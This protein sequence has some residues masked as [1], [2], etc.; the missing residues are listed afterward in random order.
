MPARPEAKY[1]ILTENNPEGNCDV[2]FAELYAMK[3][4]SYACWQL[5]IG[6]NGTEHFQIFLAFEKKTRL[7]VIQKILPGCHAEIARNPAEA[8]EY[9]RKED[10]RIEGPWTIG[11]LI[12]PKNNAKVWALIRDEVKQGLKLKDLCEKYPAQVFMYHKGISYIAS[13]YEPT[14]DF[15][16]VVEVLIGPPGCGKSRYARSYSDSYW[17]QPDSIWFDGY[18]GEKTVVLDDFYGSLPWSTMLQIMDRYATRVQVKG[19]SANFS[20]EKLII[21]SNKMPYEWYSK[22]FGT[23]KVDPFALFRRIDF[24]KVWNKETNT[25]DVW[26]GDTN[27][28]AMDY[29]GNLWNSWKFSRENSPE[30]YD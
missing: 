20:P 4:I 12:L 1:W 13:L 23:G 5:E 27:P 16:T 10:T 21:T 11:E 15:K 30:L 28:T 19:G 7:S 17:K 9:C 26:S 6:E 8:A 14:R 29:L 2:I 24:L 22:L 3:K 25:F 18:Q